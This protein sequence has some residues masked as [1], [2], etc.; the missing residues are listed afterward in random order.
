M[1]EAIDLTKRYSDG[2][3]ALDVL[4]LRVE[5]GEIYCLLGAPGAG[6]TTTINLFLGLTHPTAGRVM[7]RGIDPSSQPQEIKRHLSF[8]MADIT[9]YDSLT[10]RQ[11]IELFSRL[12][13]LPI[14]A[15]ADLDMAMREVGLPER[16]FEQR[17]G[18][19]NRGMRQKLGLAVAISRK[20]PALL[21]DEPLTGLDP[22]TSEELVETLQTLRE[23]GLAILLATQ[24]LF[25]AKQLAN[26]ASILKEGRQVLVCSREELRYRDL[27]DLYL[28]YMRGGLGRKVDT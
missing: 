2:T 25:H 17:V 26:T 12:G 24:D 4:N 15:P 18:H 16:A 21:L 7:I 11:N 20:A 9:L 13:D 14:R 23:Q 5:P 28:G 27:E 1:I 19:F 10:A 22:Q 6:K 3:L 8:L